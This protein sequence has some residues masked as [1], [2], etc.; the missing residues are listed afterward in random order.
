MARILRGDIWWA[1]LDPTRGHEQAGRRPILILSDDIF[2]GRTGTIIG[3]ALTS[4]PQKVGF[5]L[6]I[7]L[8]RTKLPKKSWVKV[9]QIRTLSNQRLSRRISHADPEEIEM[10]V[11]ALNEIIRG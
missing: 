1:D 7:E 2:N 9:G 8:T 11:E 4:Q 3:V 5:P 10:I 6:A